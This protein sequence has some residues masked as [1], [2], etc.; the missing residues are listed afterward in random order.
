M[1]KDNMKKNIY[2]L[3]RPPKNKYEL[4]EL[5]KILNKLCVTDIMETITKKY[6]ESHIDKKNMLVKNKCAEN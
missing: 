2:K 6:P 1:I 4:K 3:N 5:I